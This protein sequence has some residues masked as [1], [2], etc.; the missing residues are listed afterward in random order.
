M[1]KKTRR[2]IKSTTSTSSSKHEISEKP[3]GPVILQRIRHADASIRQAALS[4]ILHAQMLHRRSDASSMKLLLAVREQ[5]MNENVDCA[6]AAAECLSDYLECSDQVD[7]QLTAGWVALLVDRL[8]QPQQ[9][10][11]VI[12]INRLNLVSESLQMLALL[13]EDNT[14]AMNRLI[15]NKDLR[16]SCLQRILHWLNASWQLPL[17]DTASTAA[18]VST[19]SDVEQTMQILAA[20]CLESLLQD[21]ADLFELLYASDSLNIMSMFQNLS[22]LLPIMPTTSSVAVLHLVGAWLSAWSICKSGDG[23]DGDDRL[24]SLLQLLESRLDAC[25]GILSKTIQH[26]LQEHETLRLETLSQA[27]QEWQADMVDQELDRDVVRKVN[28]RKEPARQIVKRLARQ[29]QEKQQ[30]QAENMDIAP[31]CLQDKLVKV[32]ADDVATA[33]ICQFNKEEVWYTLLLDYNSQMIRPVSLALELTANLLLPFEEDGDA[34]M[35]EASQV[36]PLMQTL[37]DKHSL[38]TYTIDMMTWL[39]SISDGDSAIVQTIVPPPVKELLNLLASK[40]GTCV[41]HAL[42]HLPSFA[43]SV[44]LWRQL[45]ETLA[46]YMVSGISHA[47]VV[48]VQKMTGPACDKESVAKIVMEWL[49]ATKGKIVVEDKEHDSAELEL[50][51]RDMICMLG[52]SILPTS[53]DALLAAGTSVLVNASSLEDSIAIRAERLNVLIDL[54]SEDDRDNVFKQ[55]G[56]LSYFQRELPLLQRQISLYRGSDEVEFF[57]ETAVNASRFIQY[58]K[59]YQ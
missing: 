17:S 3:S 43:A 27:Y 28:A 36:H 19:R 41:T 46:V 35:G 20:R 44:E 23:N 30:Q 33:G 32:G 21:N 50:L 37:I 42:Q 18:A 11:D 29:R 54:F 39:R 7:E 22:D 4:G 25:I 16:E 31:D 15:N 5:Y 24:Q 57:Q 26:A 47:M 45:H 38:L 48:C 34:V 6:V 53:A 1:G 2:K 8:Q 12:S 56:M 9:P 59:G 51:T 55:T 14:V 10:D 52:C 13:I 40:L 49:E 58:K